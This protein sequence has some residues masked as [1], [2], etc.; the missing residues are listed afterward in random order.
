MKTTGIIMSR[1]PDAYTV[2]SDAVLARTA[3]AI[4]AVGVLFITFDGQRCEARVH[5]VEVTEG[6]L[7]A[8]LEWWD[9][10]RHVSDCEVRNG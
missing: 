1:Q 8:T 3:D 4:R 7:L 10:E 5:K 9:V 6:G 2:I